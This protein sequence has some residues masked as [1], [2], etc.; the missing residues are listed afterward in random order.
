MKVY[1]V[2]CGIIKTSQGYLI[3]K[4]DTT[5]RSG[6]W[7]FPGGGVEFGETNEEAIC[8][9]LKEELE[10]DCK[11]IS[12]LY[13]LMD[14]RNGYDIHVSAYLCEWLSGDIVL[15]DHSEYHFVDA[16][17][18]YDYRFEKADKPLLDYINKRSDENGRTNI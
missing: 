13:D 12:Y 15:H 2:V 8:R 16:H 9:E 10:I 3:A 18:L 5:T 1:E 4:R 17:Q 6:Y 11:V 7:E 14:H